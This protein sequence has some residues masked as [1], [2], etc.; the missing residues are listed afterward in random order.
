M[1]VGAL[2]YSLCE[3]NFEAG[4]QSIKILL[5][6]YKEAPIM[7]DQAM[8]GWNNLYPVESDSLIQRAVRMTNCTGWESYN[9]HQKTSLIILGICDRFFLTMTCQN[10]ELE[11][12]QEIIQSFQLEK[13]PK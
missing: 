2:T 12:L 6:D 4:N 1:Q 5:F 13:F 9:K 3:K 11:T 10:V 7:Y 8:R